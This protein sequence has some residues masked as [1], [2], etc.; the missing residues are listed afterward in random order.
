[1]L[2]PLADPYLR[3]TGRNAPRGPMERR[4]PISRWDLLLGCALALLQAPVSAQ[5]GQ[6]QYTIPVVF[7][8]LH[9]NGPENIW[10]VQI[11]DAIAILNAHFDA[12]TETIEAPFEAIVADMDI[13]FV[14]ASVAPDGYP[15]NGIDRIETAL[16]NDAGAPST[17][18]NPWPRNRYLNIWVVRSLATPNIAYISPLPTQSDS[19]PCSDGVMILHAYVGSIGTSAPIRK[20]TL[21]QAVGRFLNLK[22]VFEDPIAGGPCADDEVEDTPPALPDIVCSGAANPCA[23]IVANEHN[24]MSSPYCSNMFTM[25]QRARVHAC[26]TSSVAQRDQL[27]S[28]TVSDSPACSTTGLEE[29]SGDVLITARPNPFSDRIIVEGLPGQ[30]VVL[31]LLDPTGRTVLQPRTARGP[32]VTLEPGSLARGSYFVQ[33][34]T[35]NGMVVRKLIRE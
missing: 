31:E 11:A 12:P 8:V 33:V 18:L 1:M 6:A 23:P 22:M 29:S 4:T 5:P 16:T 7:H 21:T 35:R 13:A 3:T 9:E 14:L 27:A 10:A 19:T 28:G 17:Y 30:E 20:R 2:D 25:G 26:L 34:T 15:T 32:V 24:F